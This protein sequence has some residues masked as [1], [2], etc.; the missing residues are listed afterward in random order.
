[1]YNIYLYSL[2]AGH[3]VSPVGID[4]VTPITFMPKQLHLSATEKQYSIQEY[5]VT[6][7]F[8][9]LLTGEFLMLYYCLLILKKILL[10]MPSV[11]G[12]VLSYFKILC[13]INRMDPD[14]MPHFVQSHPSLYCL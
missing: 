10:E 3:L 1:M 8:N 2:T 6:I 13:F 11:V 14:E 9:S 4:L 12:R 7:W 5:R